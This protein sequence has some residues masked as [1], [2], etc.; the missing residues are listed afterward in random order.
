MFSLCERGT[1]RTAKKNVQ[2]LSSCLISIVIIKG[3]CGQKVIDIIYPI[4]RGTILRVNRRRRFVDRRRSSRTVFNSV[5][6]VAE[7]FEYG[8]VRFSR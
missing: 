4:T 5:R 1:S 6:T 2:T 7:G 3:L 8:Q